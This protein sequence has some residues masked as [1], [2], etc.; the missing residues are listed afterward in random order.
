M[1]KLLIAIA[2]ESE[3]QFDESDL[4]H[5]AEIVYT[6]VG[7]VSAAMSLALAIKPDTRA[8]L[9]I[10]T[11]GVLT[12]VSSDADSDIGKLIV[13]QFVCSTGV[14]QSSTSILRARRS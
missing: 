8:V 1:S 14:P 2:V 9:N 7:K 12:S 11:A 10:G 6:G 5:W 4:P 3:A 13:P